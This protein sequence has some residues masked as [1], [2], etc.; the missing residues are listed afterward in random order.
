PVTSIFTLQLER[1]IS[2]T[3]RPLE[4]SKIK[5]RPAVR[6]ARR[7]QGNARQ[8]KL[9]QNSLEEAAKGVAKK[10][11]TAECEAH[12]AIEVSSRTADDLQWMDT[13]DRGDIDRSCI[14]DRNLLLV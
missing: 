9:H 3:S 11:S 6:A 8:P 5:R 13:V 10:A 7:L 1:I 2:S 12:T 4:Y 14:F